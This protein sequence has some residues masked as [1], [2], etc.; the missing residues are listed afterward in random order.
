MTPL[1]ANIKSLLTVPPSLTT[2]AA[3]WRKQEVLRP[4][5]PFSTSGVP[6]VQLTPICNKSTYWVSTYTFAGPA[7]AVSGKSVF[8]ATEI[9]SSFHFH[10]SSRILWLRCNHTF[11]SFPS[12]PAPSKKRIQT[13]LHPHC[14]LQISGLVRVRLVFPSH[15]MQLS[16]L[17][18]L[19]P[20]K[21]WYITHSG[22]CIGYISTKHHSAKRSKG[23]FEKPKGSGISIFSFKSQSLPLLHVLS[24]LFFL[25]D[26][27]KKSLR[28]S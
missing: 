25:Q 28:S 9:K 26:N 14:L 16:S 2:L 6:F 17:S 23:S 27:N 1:T 10:D 21:T 13:E 11:Y 15:T 4:L 8:N 18:L 7:G 12:S 20:T 3:T 22:K 24:H 5:V 19:M